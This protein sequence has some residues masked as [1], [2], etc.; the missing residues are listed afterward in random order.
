MEKRTRREPWPG[1]PPGRDYHTEIPR[2]ARDRA[3][4]GVARSRSAGPDSLAIHGEDTHRPTEA[5]GSPFFAH[6]YWLGRL[7]TAT[8]AK[9]SMRRTALVLAATATLLTT[10]A[11]AGA[12]SNHDRVVKK[13]R[14]SHTV[15]GLPRSEQLASPVSATGQP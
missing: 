14:G 6:G 3:R 5:P 12:G 15:S 8:R 9:Q 10:V 7:L 4:S 11:P 1:T 2:R 13:V